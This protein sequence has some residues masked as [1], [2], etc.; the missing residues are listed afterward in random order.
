MRIIT[1]MVSHNGIPPSYIL[2]ATTAEA[3]HTVPIGLKE[4]E[5]QEIL[6][7][8]QTHVRQWHS[9]DVIISEIVNIICWMNPFAWLLRCV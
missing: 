9:I 3:I 7:H 8:E 4:D 2:P 6:T 1:G 5:K